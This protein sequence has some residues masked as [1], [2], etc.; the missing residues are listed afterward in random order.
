M[1]QRL[2]ETANRI[3]GT[4]QVIKHLRQN[5]LCTLYLA[6]DVDDNVR[7]ML[8]QAVGSQALE[9]V[10]VPTMKEL[11]QLCGIDVGAACAAL[12]K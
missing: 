8:E 10:D 9:I 1:P 7:S 3:V 11:G 12:L 5:R 4:K 2:S 6:G